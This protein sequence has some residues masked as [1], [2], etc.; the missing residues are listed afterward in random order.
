MKLANNNKI[1]CFSFNKFESR[2]SNYLERQSF[3]RIVDQASILEL[4]KKNAHANAKK[5]RDSIW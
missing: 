5:L 3:K 2:K 1:S 4:I